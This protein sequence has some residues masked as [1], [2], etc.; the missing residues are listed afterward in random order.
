[1]YDKPTI[2]AL[3]VRSYGCFRDH[4][5]IALLL[6]VAPALLSTWLSMTLSPSHEDIAQ[7]G[8]VL[9]I[10]L[11]LLIYSL[12]LLRALHSS[13]RPYWP[14]RIWWDELKAVVAILLFWMIFAV[15]L[16]GLTPL[17]IYV[18]VAPMV[19]S[20]LLLA[21]VYVT[22][23]RMILLLP[24]IVFEREG[25]ISSMVESWSRTKG[26][27]L[28]LLIS[29]VIVV[30]PWGAVIRFAPQW[31]AIEQ[32]STVDIVW[33]VV[34]GYLFIAVTGLFTYAVYD[35]QKSSA[36]RPEIVKGNS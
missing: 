35:T 34:Q 15:P 4:G 30:G 11:L 28:K 22:A 1:M 23:L 16:W 26:L 19:G 3:V 2:P 31:F 20:A 7:I 24:L 33:S 27:T 10:G 18:G 8:L 13:A 29:T 25:P 17:L 6:A 21:G 32:G 9:G 36:T 12:A 14:Y 5:L